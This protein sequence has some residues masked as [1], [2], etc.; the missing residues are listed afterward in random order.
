MATPTKKTTTA[1]PKAVTIS[2]ALVAGSPVEEIVWT[3]LPNGVREDRSGTNKNYLKLSVFIAPRLRV[4]N[5]PMEPRLSSFP[6]FID[7]P[8]RI[9][10]MEFDVQFSS[11]PKIRATKVGP[12]PD[13]SLWKAIFTSKTK[14][15]SFRIPD[16]H[17]RP[18][19]DYPIKHVQDYIKTK[20]QNLGA[21]PI[22]STELPTYAQLAQDDTLGRIALAPHEVLVAD[23]DLSAI[24]SVNKFASLK[25]NITASLSKTMALPHLE[26]ADPERDFARLIMAHEPFVS[27][28]VSM[29]P[30]ELDFHSAVSSLTKY[31]YIMRL[32]GLV[33]DLEIELTADIPQA[34]AVKVLPDWGSVQASATSS[35]PKTAYT[36][37][38]NRFMPAP[39]PNDSDIADGMLRLESN[40]FDVLTLDVDAAAT[41][42]MAV[43]NRAVS[44]KLGADVGRSREK[45][46]LPALRTGGISIVRNG[47]AE[48]THKAITSSRSLYAL[49]DR[50]ADATLYADDLMRG[51]R[52]DVWD[53]KSG[54]WNSLCRR[55]GTY[56]FLNANKEITCEDEGF[57][58]SAVTK[59]PEGSGSSD[60]TLRVS[61]S[62]FTWNGWSLCAPRPGKSV[63]LE[64]KMGNVSN[65]P[66]TEFR[67]KTAF[68]ATKG[69][70][71]KLRYGHSYRLR[72]RVV[73]LAGNSLDYDELDPADFSHAT[74][75]T[76]YGRFEPVASPVVVQRV[77]PKGKA[78]Q[79]GTGSGP[80]KPGISATSGTIK[81]PAVDWGSP[82]ESVER[83]VIRSFNSKPEDDSKVAKQTTDRHIAP[84]KSAQLMAETHGMFDDPA[85][86]MKTR[87]AQIKAHD[88]WLKEV[89][90]AEKLDLP[91]LPDP[92][93]LGASMSGLPGTSGVR[94]VEFYSQ[95]K[96]PEAQPFRLK[97]V[98]G[99]AAPQWDAA[100]RVLTVSLPKAE[101]AEF[102]LSSNITEENLQ[103]A[104]VWHWLEQTASDGPA[105]APVTAPKATGAKPVLKSGK[106]SA[107]STAKTEVKN[108]TVVSAVPLVTLKNGL[109]RVSISNEAL[110]KLKVS[111]GRGQHW[112]ITPSK[113]VT[114]VHAVQQPLMQPKLEIVAD[115]R[116]NDTGAYLRGKID[117]HP[118]STSKVE[119]IAAWDEPVDPTSEKKWRTISG[120]A[121]VFEEYNE[122]DQSTVDY[123]RQRQEFHDTKYRKV[124]YHSVATTRFREYFSP[125]ITSDPARIS[126]VGPEVA[127]D[128]LSTARP[129]APKV[130]YVV[131]TFGWSEPQKSGD[132]VTHTRTGGGLRVYLDRPWFSSGEGELLGV[133]LTQQGAM[134]GETFKPY[135]TMWGIDPIWEARN[136]PTT[137]PLAEQ[138]ANAVAIG[139]DLSISEVPSTEQGNGQKVC[140]AGHKV[141]YDEERQLWYCDIVINPQSA[142]MPFIRLALAR[143]QPKS[144]G[145]AHLSRVVLADYAQLT[146][147][148]TLVVTRKAAGKLSVAVKGIGVYSDTWLRNGTSEIEASI[149]RQRTGASDELAW[150][151]VSNNTVVLKPSQSTALMTTWAGEVSLPQSSG[152]YRLI[153]KEYERY[154]VDKPFSDAGT[155]KPEGVV[156]SK[157]TPATDRRLVYADTLELD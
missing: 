98:E 32:L 51:F 2:P 83:L 42:S 13:S 117:I 113:T 37:K 17:A 7:W 6:D 153:V 122:V 120:S 156:F 36:I 75:P 99:N 79:A 24:A 103:R 14:V 93:A 31:P 112:M 102:S 58:S 107:A 15:E 38:N 127:V 115:R 144:V 121:H 11:K 139:K 141:E 55:S 81:V 39:K 137:V 92:L 119:L 9:K 150:L 105:L 124:R 22:T 25:T 34:A 100:A 84:P 12:E 131:P 49:P 95:T 18:I 53:S 149:E 63:T 47:R 21:D 3:A 30:P 65:E 152:K 94:T 56:R 46:G 142:Y 23:A 109:K 60:Q 80:A 67:L 69:S 41:S 143:Y 157:P 91:Y 140:V 57:V 154:A 90:P 101:V 128:V 88:G 145:N 35:T 148:R 44:L 33:I 45:T 76:V 78:I 71:P 155:E 89:E 20:Y 126:R 70:L 133:V 54:K 146:P 27:T 123:V 129:A 114:L 110:S 85:N 66:S 96:W 62:M 77:D 72:A 64:D 28:R 73:D 16:Y 19:L 52:V 1:R 134:P 104:G 135:V 136:V 4:A 40:L 86:P 97:L 68:A 132:T 50:G 82:G 8:A 26:A 48:K 138:F 118:K 106:A 147:D 151:P 29:K 10:A 87:Y 74:K 5:T 59:A 125:I 61:Q 130:L 43:A 111:A 108:Q 116:I